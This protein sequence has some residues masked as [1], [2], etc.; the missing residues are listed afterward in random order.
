MLS[1]VFVLAC[2][3]G[4]SMGSQATATGIAIQE[5]TELLHKH[6]EAETEGTPGA[7]VVKLL[8]EMEKSEENKVKRS[9][10]VSSGGS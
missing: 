10:A 8:Q 9:G 2:L 6:E 3:L 5:G 7:R 4:T 1:A